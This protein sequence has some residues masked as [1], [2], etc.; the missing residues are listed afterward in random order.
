M[1]VEGL[2]FLVSAPGK[3]IIFGE[4]S[5]VYN[6]PAIA[7]SVSSLRT[8]ML[9]SQSSDDSIELNF[10]DIKFD[11]VWKRQ[12]LE[13]VLRE[14]QLLAEARNDT[15][16]LNNVLV[17]KLNV[18]LEPLRESLH[19]HAA[20]CF[21]YLYCCLCPEITNVKFSVKSTLPIGAGLGSSASISVA[22]S[23]A[24]LRLG[25]QLLDK[26]VLEAAD[27]ACINEWAFIGEKC[28][29]GTP[30]GIDNAVATYG[31][32]VLFQRSAD[33]NTSFRFL[34][35]FNE[36]NIPMVL[37]YTGIPRS[38]KTLVS[39]VRDL[40]EKYPKIVSDHII[41]AMGELASE[42]ESILN[43]GST[44]SDANY[45]R[46]L[47]L[48]NINHGLLVSIGVSH[49]GLEIIRSLSI[50][51]NIGATKLT[52][53]GGGGCAFTILN[54][55]TPNDEVEKFK[56]QLSK[57]YKYLSFTSDLGGLGCCMSHTLSLDQ[58]KTVN[59]LFD[60]EA[61]VKEKLNEALLPGSKK[62]SLSWI[63]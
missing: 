23:M 47:D 2:P 13:M 12:E 20:F 62:V 63:Y 31:N 14:T 56:A 32:A 19:Y 29:H 15:K 38:T 60:N 49:P 28:I 6:E 39:A 8:Y 25:G 34:E 58:R 4:H 10:P 24:M 42:S 36:M 27:K 59:P 7:A 53:A 16:N 1:T 33:G 48:V 30:S 41:R 52:G 50:E 3:V 54:K 46:L 22:L 17:D 61:T 5:A 51:M 43:S 11:H 21:L 44:D 40:S 37:T 55:D 18:I 26:P 35:R 57:Q 9:V 45:Q